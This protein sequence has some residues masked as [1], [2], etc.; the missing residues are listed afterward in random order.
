MAYA[1]HVLR[2]VGFLKRKK[3]KCQ[4]D[5]CLLTPSWTLR[6]FNTRLMLFQ[7]LKVQDKV[8]ANNW[9]AGIFVLFIICWQ[10]MKKRGLKVSFDRWFVQLWLWWIVW[11]ISSQ[12]KFSFTTNKTWQWFQSVFFALCCSAQLLGHLLPELICC[13]VYIFEDVKQ[14]K[15]TW[16]WRVCVW[17]N[18]GGKSAELDE[19]NSP[20]KFHKY[21]ERVFQ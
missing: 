9:L 2:S 11:K 4:P 21:A 13:R 16:M 19:L 14:K 15:K 18:E 7:C 6:P 20:P 1:R 5:S 12:V 3:Q 17:K 8:S 10:L